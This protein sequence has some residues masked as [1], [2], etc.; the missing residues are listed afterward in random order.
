MQTKVQMTP[1]D[2]AAVMHQEKLPGMKTRP[3]PASMSPLIKKTIIFK[4]Q[5]VQD[6]LFSTDT[7]IFVIGAVFS[8]NF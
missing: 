4:H 6:C 3:A 7:V 1:A 8:L 2:G 5:L